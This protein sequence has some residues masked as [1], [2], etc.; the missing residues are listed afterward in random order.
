MNPAWGVRLY[1]S[2]IRVKPTDA[3]NCGV[4][5]SHAADGDI[6]QQ[7]LSAANA[8]MAVGVDT[9]TGKIDYHGLAQSEAFHHYALS[10]QALRVFDLETLVDDQARRAFWINLYNCLVIHA[11]VDWKVEGKI[12]SPYTIFDRMAYVVGGYRFSAND[13]EHGILRANAGHPYIPGPQFGADDPR[14]AYAVHELDPR[15]HFTLVCGAQS[16]PP[17]R[18]Y[19]A[20][21]MDFQ[22]QVAA[23]NFINSGRVAIDREKLTVA[24]SRLFSWYAADFGAALY[25]YRGRAHLLSYIAGYLQSEDDA[26]FVREHA[27]TL[28]IRFLPYDWTLNDR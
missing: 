24:L 15:V 22:L 13:I 18:H 3:L 8:M 9:E 4:K 5:P 6:P 10:T 20:D 23:T 17:I 11:L 2:L 16:C 27:H 14:L 21:R 19:D 25:G 12:S 7:L 26:A 28:R 1:T